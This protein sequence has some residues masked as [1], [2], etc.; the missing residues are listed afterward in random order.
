MPPYPCQPPAE[1][2][3]Q[4]NPI[5]KILILFS[6]KKKIQT[7]EIIPRTGIDA[8]DAVEYCSRSF[9]KEHLFQPIK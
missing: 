1:S 6:A 2:I 7:P 5:P 9:L 4:N 8:K 3:D